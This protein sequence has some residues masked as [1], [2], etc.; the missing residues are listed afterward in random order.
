MALSTRCR[1]CRELTPNPIPDTCPGCGVAFDAA[2]QVVQNGIAFDEVPAGVLVDLGLNE[3]RDY[4]RQVAD[5]GRLND[6]QA[7]EIAGQD[8]AGLVGE[9]ERRRRALPA[10][11]ATPPEPTPEPE[12]TGIDLRGAVRDIKS[13]IAAVDDVEQLRAAQQAEAE[14]EKPRKGVL[15]ALAERLAA[16][17]ESA[18]EAGK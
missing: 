4:V 17:S 16:R 5:H 13:R 15:D 6:L 7:A 14:A 8:R 12:P 9:I 10:A 11:S 3:L 1:S 2:V 18:D